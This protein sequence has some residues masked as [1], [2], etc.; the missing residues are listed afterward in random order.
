MNRTSRIR[1]LLA[2]V[3]GVIAPLLV[4]M[5]AQ[6]PDM[7][8]VGQVEGSLEVLIAAGQGADVVILGAPQLRPPPGIISHLLNAFPTIKV[9]LFSHR[10][11]AAVGYW[12]GVRRCPVKVVTEQS[13]LADVRRLHMLTPTV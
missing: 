8:L 9:M 7:I 13:I 12:L 1:V 11:D 3:P 5:I 4:Q 10:E 2:D 6:Q